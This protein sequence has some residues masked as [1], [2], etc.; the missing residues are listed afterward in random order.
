MSGWQRAAEP[1]EPIA[2][3][4]LAAPARTAAPAATGLVAR[5]P[6]TPCLM[7]VTSLQGRKRMALC[8][9]A[10]TRAQPQQHGCAGEDA[11][12]N[13]QVEAAPWHGVLN[14]RNAARELHMEQ[15]DAH[16]HA[17][18]PRQAQERVDVLGDGLGA[19]AHGGLH[20]LDRAV[21]CACRGGALRSPQTPSCSVNA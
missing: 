20:V 19:R 5:T 13:A 15:Q 17:Q 1:I 16:L 2:R 21:G 7:R 14:V 6:K 9:W 11:P 4:A 18:R 10:P 8:S 3:S 12:L